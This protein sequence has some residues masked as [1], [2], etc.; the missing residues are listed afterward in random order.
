MTLKKMLQISNLHVSIADKEIIK[1]L[2]LTIKSGEI[3]ALLGPNGCGKSSL[4][5]ALAGHP[6]Y[7][8]KIPISKCRIENVDLLGMSP[9]KRAKAGLFLVFQNPVTL[10]GVGIMNFL[11]S[12]YKQVYPT[13]NMALFEFRQLVEKEAK[14]VGLKPELLTRNVNEGFSGGERKRLEVLQLRLLRPK[15]AVVDEIDSGLDIDGLK[16]AALAINQS[17]K[18]FNMGCLVITHHQKLLKYLKP[19]MVHAMISGKIIATGK[20]ELL[21]EIENKGYK[22]FQM[23]S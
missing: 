5:Y 11:R 1:G 6:A 23:S 3:H 18:Q 16:S 2:D 19:N 8:V 12:I 10:D 14:L 20:E 7:T 13:D 22:K 17:V 4:A 21:E 9:D 15:F